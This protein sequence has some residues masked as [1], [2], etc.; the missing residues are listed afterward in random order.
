MYKYHAHPFPW[1]LPLGT[2]TRFLV[3][4]PELLGACGE[5]RKH[6]VTVA[7]PLCIVYPAALPLAS[8][9]IPTHAIGS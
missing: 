8:Q 6:I 2:L 9:S 7:P 1:H 5:N 4:R 3:I